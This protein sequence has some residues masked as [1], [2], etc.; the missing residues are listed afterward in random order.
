MIVI[1]I[2]VT[3]LVWFVLAGALFF[4]PVVDKIYRKQDHLPGVRALPP[5]PKTVGM[6]MGAIV[7]QITLWALVY[8][9]I[10]PA[11]PGTNWEKGL[12]FGLILVAMKMIPRD[13]DRLLLSTY[14]QRRLIIEFIIGVINCFAIG[15]TFAFLN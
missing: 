15:L 14:P 11:L 4:N 12:I 1:S 8:S 9:L 10:A 13:A 5:S 7:L 6:I 3:S 2:I